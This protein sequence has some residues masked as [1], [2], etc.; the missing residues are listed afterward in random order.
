MRKKENIDPIK[1][2]RIFFFFQLQKALSY[3]TLYFVFMSIYYCFSTN[4][5]CLSARCRYFSVSHKIK[6]F[7]IHGFIF[8]LKQFVSTHQDYIKMSAM[9]SQFLF[10][11]Q[12]KWICFNP[13]SVFQ[14]AMLCSIYH[15]CYG[16]SLDAS[17][18][19]PSWVCLYISDGSYSFFS[20]G[21]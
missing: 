6:H 11:F 1:L 19:I 4:I 13:N 7:P 9:R 15:S 10:N 5:H 17:S 8:Y 16:T 20:V 2:E 14:T 12:F 21:H 18:F 3:F